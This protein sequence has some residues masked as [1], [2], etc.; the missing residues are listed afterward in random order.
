[1]PKTVPPPAESYTQLREAALDKNLWR[2]RNFQPTEKNPNLWGLV[3]EIGTVHNAVTLVCMVDGSVELYV[4]NGGGISGGG[5]KESVRM[6]AEEFIQAGETF[7]KK[8]N[9]TK[10]FPLPEVDRVRFYALT[11][12]GILTAQDNK[13]MGDEKHPFFPLLRSGSEVIGAMKSVT[14]AN[15]KSSEQSAK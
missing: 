7:L 13:N 6:K 5:E 9:P 1:M 8:F 4:G 15:A 2:R 3:M 10:N 14:D 11:Y 12:D